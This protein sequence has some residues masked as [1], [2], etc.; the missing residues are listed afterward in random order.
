M[1]NFEKIRMS[2]R[3][4]AASDDAAGR[5][6]LRKKLRQDAETIKSQRD[7]MLADRNGAFAKTLEKV[8]ETGKEVTK[9]RENVLD[10][11]NFEACAKILQLRTADL[12]SSD[13]TKPEVELVIRGL[14]Q[15]FTQNAAFDWCAMGAA[16]AVFF[17]RV[18]TM[19]LLRGPLSVQAKA[20]KTRAARQARQ[21]RKPAT[22]LAASDA[23]PAAGD[24]STKETTM[25]IDALETAMFEATGGE[26]DAH[27]IE[28]NKLLTQPASFAQTVENFFDFAFL[29]RWGK[30]GIR[31]NEE[32]G[33]VLVERIENAVEDATQGATQPPPRSSGGG[34]DVSATQQDATRSGVGSAETQAVVTLNM[35]Q[36]RDVIKAFKLKDGPPFIADRSAGKPDAER[37]PASPGKRTRR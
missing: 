37:L 1:E 11:E 14:R 31:Y 8:E 4:R 20:P 24:T 19:S 2:N 29:L 15:K 25:R 9:P 36:Y 6:G 28:A 30:A 17:R 5:R 13:C 33:E 32:T 35:A 18:P 3:K 23:A 34:G 10:A 16:S 26:D 27:P 22:V 7:N 12:N 21:V